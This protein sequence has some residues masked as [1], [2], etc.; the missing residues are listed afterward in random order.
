[1]LNSVLPRCLLAVAVSCGAGVATASELDRFLDGVDSLQGR[2]EQRQFDEDGAVLASSTGD[3]WIRRPDRFRWA[4]RQPY[5]QLVVSDGRTIWIHDP[6]LEQVTR[7]AAGAALAGTP[8]ALL[9]RD[10]SAM[11]GFEIQALGQQDGASQWRL[12]PRSDEGDFREVRLWLRAAVPI[13]LEF[14]D[15]LGGTTRI[16]L[17]DSVHDAEIDPERFRFTPPPGAEVVDG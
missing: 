16:D 6:D 5:E 13:R 8:A 17:I 14:T 7:R 11:D 15:Q 3:F 4:Y 2:F 12:V 10:R 9:S 1:M